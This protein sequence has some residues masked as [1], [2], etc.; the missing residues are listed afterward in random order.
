MQSPSPPANIVDAIVV[1]FVQVFAPGFEALAQLILATMIAGP[2]LSATALLALDRRMG[3]FRTSNVA[4]GIAAVILTFAGAYAFALIA[5]SLNDALSA[6]GGTYAWVLSASLAL[7]A[8][9]LLLQWRAR[10]SF[11][12]ARATGVA[13][14]ILTP[15]AL[16]AIDAAL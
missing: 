6:V 3:L 11:S 8:V 1:G 15:L 14:A 12:T 16:I 7:A 4:N 9:A 2:A 13:C 5:T 10:A